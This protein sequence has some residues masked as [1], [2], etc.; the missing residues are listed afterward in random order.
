M[1]DHRGVE[2]VRRLGDELELLDAPDRHL[3]VVPRS[4]AGHVHLDPV[5][6]ALHLA[7]D[8]SHDGVLVGDDLRV[9]GATL[10]GDQVAGGPADRGH[11]RVGP[12]RHAGALDEAGLDGDPESGPDVVDAV[13]IEEACDAGAQELL[14]VERREESS[15]CLVAVVEELVVGLRLPEG[16]VAVG[17]DE[18]RHHGHASHVDALDVRPARRRVKRRRPEGGDAVALQEQRFTVT[19]RRSSAID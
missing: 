6:T 1:P 13:G 5:G 7:S 4:P 3:P 18:A 15:R 11:E 9:A 19:R 14:D 12:G 17:V 2:L 8:G 10:V 16:Y